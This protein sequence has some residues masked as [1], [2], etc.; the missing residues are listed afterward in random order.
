MKRMNEFMNSKVYE[1]LR[2]HALNEDSPILYAMLQSYNHNHERWE[3]PE[4]FLADTIMALTA[5]LSGTQ[6]QLVDSLTRSRPVI[7]TCANCGQS[8]IN[9]K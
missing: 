8:P 5:A 9:W 4:A 1:Q 3:T 2:M 6:A 7:Y